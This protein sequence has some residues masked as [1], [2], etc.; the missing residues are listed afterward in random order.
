M[1][2][3]F[4]T[5]ALMGMGCSDYDL[6]HGNDKKNGPDDDKPGEV[7]GP[8]PDI[9]VEPSTVTFGWLMLDCPGDPQQI[10]VS[11][12]GDEPL[13]VD[14]ASIAGTGSSTFSLSG[15]VRDLDPGESFQ[16]TVDFAPAAY[17]DYDVDVVI[18]SNDPDEPESTVD[19]IGHGSE[20]SMYEEYFKQPD[21]HAMDVLWVVDN[22]GSMS[23]VVDL[24]GERFESFLTSFDSMGID[25]QIGVVST[26]M[27]TAD[28]RG[29][30]RGTDKVISPSDPDP[31]ATFV[32]NTALGTGGSANE[33]GTDA[34]YAALTD[35]LISGDNAG[36]IREDAM[37]AVVVIS[38][39]DDSSSINT[40]TFS[41]WLN[42]Y[43][44]D[45]AKTSFSGIIGDPD[46]WPIGCTGSGF[47]PVTA[48]AGVQYEKVINSTGGSWQ[49]ICDKDFDKML[50]YLAY[51][52]S[53][54][55]FD[56]PLSKKP[57]SVFDIT[58]EVDGVDIPRS[59]SSGWTYDP[60]L[61]T[62]HF[63]YSVI[64]GPES[65]VHIVYPVEGDC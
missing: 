58:V 31:V 37:L 16:L 10:T 57:T 62:I 63:H 4:I 47:P 36:L 40:S 6:N 9:K 50:S 34:A 18:V 7:D 12:V 46:N 19:A 44:G 15:E 65:V 43:K 3:F 2:T 49:S 23:G 1:R 20:N 55:V 11:N 64:P 35:P 21:V 17:M 59:M 13:T 39:E 51:G 61:N 38:D 5:L 29:M 45:P 42:G 52:S 25:Y 22:S 33:Q 14:S 28:H 26:D 60:A 24:L 8:Q 53:G 30:L 32:A 48:V 56:F 54:L 27:E 41:S